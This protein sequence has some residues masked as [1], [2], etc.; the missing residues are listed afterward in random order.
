MS[1]VLDSIGDAVFYMFYFNL[2]I[3]CEKVM[4]KT[5]P[6]K[7]SIPL[8]DED[9]SIMVRCECYG[10]ALEVTH[11][12]NK[13][14][15]DEFWFAIWQQGFKVPL[16]WRE[17]IRWCWNILRKGKPWKDNIILT[18]EHAKQVADFI[19]QH[20]PHGNNPKL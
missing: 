6:S 16:C 1:V 11:W 12:R 2:K 9:T 15:P 14:C 19:N 10:E 5:T 18:P 13:D 3:C 7:N 17:K 4:K 20:L 8:V